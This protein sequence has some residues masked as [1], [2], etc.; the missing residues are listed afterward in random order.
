[1]FKLVVV[2][3]DGTLL[4]SDKSISD[5]TLKVLKECRNRG[6]FIAIAT[7]RSEIS[8]QGPIAKVQPDIIISSSGAKQLLGSFCIA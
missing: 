1:M 8:A 7:A 6:L 3:L 4:R 2:D 5:F